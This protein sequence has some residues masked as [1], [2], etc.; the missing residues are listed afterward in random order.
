M[1]NDA[2]HKYCITFT[3]LKPYS[4]FFC[5]VFSDYPHP[6]PRRHKESGS[7]AHRVHKVAVRE[8]A[9]SV[10]PLHFPLQSV[11]REGPQQWGG[12]VPKENAQGKQAEP[13]RHAL[14]SYVRW[15]RWGMPFDL[16]LMVIPH[17]LLHIT[18]SQVLKVNFENGHCA[19]SWHVY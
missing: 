14:P 15:R 3:P 12:V 10:W 8:G 1:V 19:L 16:S 7:Q 2:T 6:V 5:S 4:L 17:F 18:S 11:C 9:R 13:W